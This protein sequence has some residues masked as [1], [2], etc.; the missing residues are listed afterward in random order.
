MPV[1]GSGRLWLDRVSDYLYWRCQ[2]EDN[3]SQ[4]EHEDFTL[5]LQILR[6]VRQGNPEPVEAAY[7]WSF[8]I[9]QDRFLE[10]RRRREWDAAAALRLGRT[11]SAEAPGTEGGGAVLRMP[12]PGRVGAVNVPGAP[13]T[14][15]AESAGRQKA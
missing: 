8:G 13:E 1:E 9:H 14:A 2:S 15:R 4:T 7:V 11:Q 6:Q 3:R 10:A 12:Q 5:A